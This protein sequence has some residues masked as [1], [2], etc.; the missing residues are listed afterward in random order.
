MVCWSE[1]IDHRAP[2]VLSQ[3]QTLIFVSSKFTFHKYFEYSLKM[4]GFCEYFLS[5]RDHPHNVCAF[6]PFAI[7]KERTSHYKVRDVCFPVSTAE[8]TK[9]S[10]INWTL[11]IKTDQVK[12]VAR[13]L[14]NVINRHRSYVLPFIYKHGYCINCPFHVNHYDMLIQHVWPILSN[15]SLPLHYTLVLYFVKCWYVDEVGS[16][17]QCLLS[18]CLS[19]RN[20]SGPVRD[21]SWV[22]SGR[23]SLKARFTKVVRCCNSVYKMTIFI[24]A[25]TVI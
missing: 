23:K 9:L 24:I 7:T 20:F 21:H 4:C 10:H 16:T 22:A 18:P 5:V 1:D 6:N 17:L 13:R 14:F 25:T 11:T 12:E 15:S 3:V 19:G 2:G 8:Q